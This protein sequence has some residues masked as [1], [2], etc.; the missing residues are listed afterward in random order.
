M[1]I[2]GE[3]PDDSRVTVDAPSSTIS[4]GTTTG[5]TTGTTAGTAG[6][7]FVVQPDEAAAAARAAEVRPPHALRVHACV[8]GG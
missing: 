3:L 2:A 5:T 6:L 4:N 1:I 8:R 7:R